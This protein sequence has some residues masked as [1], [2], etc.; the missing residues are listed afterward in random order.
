VNWYYCVP[1][2]EYRVE[3]YD[4]LKVSIN[5]ALIEAENDEEGRARLASIGCGTKMFGTAKSSWH[6]PDEYEWRDDPKTN[7]HTA[8]AI[9]HHDDGTQ[10]F[11][12]CGCTS[13][14]ET[15]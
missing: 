2:S 9:A 7:E 13:C 15:E 6:Q 5:Y 10:S 12:Y 11:I 3:L 8:Y 14:R 4:S 1:S